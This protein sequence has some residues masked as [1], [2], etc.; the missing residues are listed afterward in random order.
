MRGVA[1]TWKRKT[2]MN[3]SLKL[4]LFWGH[5][6]VAH[7]KRMDA[8]EVITDSHLYC[9]ILNNKLVCRNIACRCLSQ[10]F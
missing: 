3:K 4:N 8:E 9:L 5:F 2:F 1:F 10:V 6:V 7:T